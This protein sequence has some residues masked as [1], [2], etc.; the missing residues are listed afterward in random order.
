MAKNVNP[1][2]NFNFSMQIVGEPIDPFLIQM[3]E[4][5]SR[6]IEIV[7]HGETNHSVKTGGRVSFGNLILEKIFTTTP[8]LNAHT[9]FED[10]MVSVQDPITGGGL[11]P[12]NIRNSGYA[13]DVIIYEFPESGVATDEAGL[14]TGTPLNIWYCRRVWPANRDSITLNRME[15]DNTIERIELAVDFIEKV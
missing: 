1:R 14:P 2:K 13:R 5:P 11:S 9:Y 8:G 15:S 10:W 7:E 6:E 4:I 3:V 12:D